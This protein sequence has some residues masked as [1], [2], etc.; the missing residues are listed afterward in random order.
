MKFVLKFFFIIL[1]ASPWCIDIL[2]AVDTAF[3]VL[4]VFFE[5]VNVQRWRS[6]CRLYIKDEEVAIQSKNLMAIKESF[7]FLITPF[8]KCLSSLVFIDFII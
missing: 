7:A 5:H 4:I 1:G 2:L 8:L 3:I 6:D